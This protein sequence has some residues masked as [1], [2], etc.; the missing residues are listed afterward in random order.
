MVKAG[1]TAGDQQHHKGEFRRIAGQVERVDMPL[2][3]VHADPREIAGIG[4]GFGE[5]KAHQQRADQPGPLGHRHG[6]NRGKP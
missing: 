1:V 2:Q 3:V 4:Q 6:L 5:R